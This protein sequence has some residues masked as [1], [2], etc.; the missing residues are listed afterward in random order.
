MIYLYQLFGQHNSIVQDLTTPPLGSR[1]KMESGGL[2]I[3]HPNGPRRRHARPLAR[4]VSPTRNGREARARI[5]PP[6]LQA[7]AAACDDGVAL[8]ETAKH[9]RGSALQR[10]G[11]ESP[12]IPE[13][14]PV[15]SNGCVGSRGTPGGDLRVVTDRTPHAIVHDLHA[16]AVR[17]LG[18]WPG[19]PV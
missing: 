14:N 9:T 5:R 19:Q 18:V 6:P 16:S 7:Q 4:A 13:S 2:T 11:R 3:V 17:L 1:V 8:R 12:S 10:G 15:A